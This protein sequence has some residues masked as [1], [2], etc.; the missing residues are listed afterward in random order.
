MI[1]K[2]RDNIGIWFRAVRVPFFTA[3]VLSGILGSI[4]AWH[5]TGNLDCFYLFLTVLGIVL[6]NAGTNLINDYFD[7]T[8]NLDEVNP[9]PTRFSGG[10]RVIQEKL[11]SPRKIFLAGLFSFTL[12]SLI[13]LYLNWQPKGNVILIIG[14]LGVFLGYFYT[15][16]PLRIGYTPMAEIVA[17]SCC[18]F[19]IIAGSYYVQAQTLNSVVFYVSIPMGLLVFLILL[20]NEFLD[21]DADKIVNKKTLVV[22]LGK[23]K[24]M[25]IYRL[26]LFFIYLIMI[27]GIIFRIFPFFTLITFITIPLAFKAVKIAKQNY[28]KI[29][30]LLPANAATI[31]LHLFFGLLLS[32]GY[33]LDKLFKANK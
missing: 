32:A 30:E 22:I 3:T 12:A 15:A 24:A 2:I 31:R 14:M 18:G 23:E 17:G 33:L 11:I 26:L 21:Y 19:L 25:R 8:S 13:G 16:E 7:H 28:N 6:L 4:C 29:Q 9:N 10:S 1:K 5:N 20:I 27:F